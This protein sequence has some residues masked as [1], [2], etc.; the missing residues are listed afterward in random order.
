MPTYNYKCGEHGY[1]ELEQRMADHAAGDC[2]TCGE[3]CKQV[4]T[5]AP[6]LDIESMARAGMPGAWETVGD[7][8]HKRHRSVSQ[9]H[10]AVVGEK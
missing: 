4:M 9:H 1:F 7:R 8:I 10:R 5:S 3:T 2:P 6:M